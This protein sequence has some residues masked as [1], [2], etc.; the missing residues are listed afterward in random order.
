[1]NEN[2]RKIHILLINDKCDGDELNS[3]K[4]QIGDQEK[5]R[6]TLRLFTGDSAVDQKDKQK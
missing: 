3:N 5:I 1:M 6:P 4:V 2:D